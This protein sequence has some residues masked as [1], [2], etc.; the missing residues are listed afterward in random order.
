MLRNCTYLFIVAV[1]LSIS[2]GSAQ[3]A[4]LPDLLYYQ[5][6]ESSWNGTPGEVTDSSIAASHHGTAVGN[7]TTADVGGPFGRVGTFD[8]S[9]DWVNATNATTLNPSSEITLEG[10]INLASI[11]PSGWQRSRTILSRKYCYIFEVN[12]EGKLG[13]Y[14]YATGY[15][16]KADHDMHQYLGEWTH[17]A[18]TYD[19]SDKVLYVNGDEV[20]RQ[21]IPGSLPQSTAYPTAVG[22][23]DYSRYF[24]GQMDEVGIHS[25]ALSHQQIR[26]QARQPDILD[27]HM[28]ELSW[29]GTPG[30]VID[31]S[32]MDHH[33]TAGGG[34][35][36]ADN[37]PAGRLGRSG[38]FD[39]SNNSVNCGAASSLVPTGSQM[40][41]EAWVKPDDLG[42]WA[43]DGSVVVKSSTYYLKVTDEGTV[44]AY[45]ASGGGTQSWFFSDEPCVADDHWYHLV[46]VRDGINES[47]WVNGVE[48]ASRDDGS[49]NSLP[50]ITANPVWIG[51]DSYHGPFKGLIDQVGIYDWALDQQEILFRY[52]MGVPEPGSL[53]LLGL[54]LVCCVLA[55]R[56]KR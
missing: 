43:K 17:V 50:N 32:G 1:L 6:E 52:S 18:A 51:Y 9:G 20:G 56:R 3:S 48:V 54:G 10:W 31:S 19:G 36:T 13:M 53:L 14:T 30:E 40:S 7:A 33:G 44:G 11:D 34:A 38:I 37:S 15:W 39:G 26:R 35:T 8:G 16:L 25:T 42:T 27:L 46:A 55:Y 28:D 47:I 29:N 45:F 2:A 23:I 21:T 41:I 22:W 24:H 49:T 12:H 5:M 4:I